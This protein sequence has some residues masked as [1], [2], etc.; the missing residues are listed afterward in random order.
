MQEYFEYLLG[1][2]IYTG[3]LVFMWG[4]GLTLGYLLWAPETSFKRGFLDSLSM[5]WL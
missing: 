4:Q 5:R 3:L 2:W 1:S